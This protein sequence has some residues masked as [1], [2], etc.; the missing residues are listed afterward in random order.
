M[1]ECKVGYYSR[2]AHELG[3]SMTDWVG[4]GAVIYKT[5]SG[6][7]VMVTAVYANKERGDSQY[8]WADA[9]Y[10]GPV[11]EWVMEVPRAFRRAVRGR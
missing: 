9:V 11:T 5:P 7:E 10:V 3:D 6:E 1:G 4:S 8:K 2:K